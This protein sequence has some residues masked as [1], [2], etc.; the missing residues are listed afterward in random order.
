MT[1]MPFAAAVQGL[2][3]GDFS[4]LEPLFEGGQGDGGPCPIIAWQV[5]GRF[6]DEPKALAEA[7]TCACFL[8]REEVAIHLLDH[9]VDPVS[10][11]GTGLNAFHWAANRGQLAIVRLLIGRHA[12]LETRNLYGGTV[13]GGAVWAA[14]HEPRPAHLEIIT[15]LLEAGARAEDAEFPTGNGIIDRVLER[16]RATG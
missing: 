15:A 16:F 2:L 11:S 8:G 5:S 13:L 14:L 4:R 9:G 6:A 7:L 1:G 3:A 12:P 10:G